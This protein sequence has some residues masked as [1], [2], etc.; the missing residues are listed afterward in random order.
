MAST[1]PRPSKAERTTTAREQ[2]RQLHERQ[3]AAAKRKSLFLKVGVVV[4]VIL[5]IGIV[6]LII[7]QN[8]RGSIADAGPAPAHGNEFGGYVL[9]ADGMKDTPA[10]TVDK[11]TIPPAG[12][13]AGGATIPPGIAAAK[14]GEPVQVVVYADLSCPVCKQFE[15][16]YGASLNKLVA[17]GKITLEYRIATFLDRMSSTN[18]SSR[19]ANALA[20]VADSKP[21][22]FAP[23]LTALFAQ[24]PA[25]G[26]EGLPNAQLTKIAADA[27]AGDVGSCIDGT[28]FRPWAQYVNATF[29]AYEV[30]GTPTAYVNG[31][32]W[33]SQSE[34]FQKLL[35]DAVAANK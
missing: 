18:Y 16:A 21:E 30:G 11:N 12:T 28:K 29:N 20:C 3:Q 31:H 7:T 15:E 1:P 32:L 19:A 35:D 27:G 8:N 10:I 24:Q 9:T 25:E 5:I 33:D 4:A 14:A 17:D 22:A 13:G 34:D 26:G 23:Y 2:A 6:A